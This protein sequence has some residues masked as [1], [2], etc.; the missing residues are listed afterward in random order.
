M[1]N[2]LVINGNVGSLVDEEHHTQYACSGTYSDTSSCSGQ[3]VLCHVNGLNRLTITQ[4]S[5]TSAT[6]ELIQ[7]TAIGSG[8]D[9]ACATDKYIQQRLGEEKFF[10]V[11]TK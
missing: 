2:E 3:M 1:M 11:L 9:A 7:K 8:D 4:S 10:F 5:A 6:V